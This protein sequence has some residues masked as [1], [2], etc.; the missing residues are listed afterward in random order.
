MSLLETAAVKLGETLVKG[1]CE[2]LTGH[3]I[4][5]DL[6]GSFPALDLN[7]VRSFPP[8][9]RRRREYRDLQLLFNFESHCVTNSVAC[10]ITP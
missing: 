10:A 5:G 9:H 7:P 2:A 1:A 3:K 4:I 6:L 8:C